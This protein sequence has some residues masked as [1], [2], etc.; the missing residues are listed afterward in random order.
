MNFFLW[1][2]IFAQP[3]HGTCL[4]SIGTPASLWKQTTFYDS[5]SYCGCLQYSCL[6]LA[7]YRDTHCIALHGSPRVFDTAAQAPIFSSVVAHKRLV[8]SDAYLL[9]KYSLVT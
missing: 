6:C 8:T 2:E 3:P 5:S 4:L 7:H 1:A 9:V